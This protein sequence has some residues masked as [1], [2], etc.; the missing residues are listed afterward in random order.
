PYRMLILLIHLIFFTE[1]PTAEIHTLSL[2]DALPISSRQERPAV[3]ICWRYSASPSRSL[4]QRLVAIPTS[5]TAATTPTAASVASAG[6]RPAQRTARR[7]TD[8]RRAAIGS[9]A[10]KRP[11]SSASA[12]ADG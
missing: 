10:R 9:P 12:P 1:T 11:R 4:Y 7:R 5:D 2:H 8:A 6:R 3:A